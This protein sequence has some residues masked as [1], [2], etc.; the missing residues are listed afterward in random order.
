MVINIDEAD[1]IERVS[2]ILP[3]DNAFNQQILK[4]LQSLLYSTSVNI[5]GRKELMKIEEIIA[6]VHHKVDVIV[7]AGSPANCLPI[8]ILDVRSSSYRV[9]RIGSCTILT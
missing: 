6:W 2:A 8:I 9:L 5:Y 3:P 7:R 4:N 1:V